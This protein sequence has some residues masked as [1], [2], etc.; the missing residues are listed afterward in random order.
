MNKFASSASEEDDGLGPITAEGKASED[1]LAT[2]HGVVAEY[3]TLAIASGKAS[4]T[5]LGAA[6]TFLKNN[7]ITADPATNQALSDLK[8][9]LAERRDRK[10]GLT[11]KVAQEADEAFG[12]LMG[13]MGLPQ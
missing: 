7:S 8:A 12:A 3:L 2:L 9:K 10:G 13:G 11:K 1:K 5:I 6:I 4:P